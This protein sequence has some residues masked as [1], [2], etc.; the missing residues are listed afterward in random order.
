MRSKSLILICAF[1][2]V[3][4]PL[5]AS[6]SSDSIERL[7]MSSDVLGAIMHTPDKGILE[8][9]LSSAKCIV[10]VP[11]LVKGGFVF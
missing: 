11:H 5:W 10:V 8:G 3:S 7:Q 6:A 2:L 4:S 1:T 9:V